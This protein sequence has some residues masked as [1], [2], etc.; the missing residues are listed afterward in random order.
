MERQVEQAFL[1]LP[2]DVRLMEVLTSSSNPS[3]LFI[4]HAC[5]LTYITQPLTL[6]L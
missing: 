4:D 5:P 1:A 3:H 6:N 2:L